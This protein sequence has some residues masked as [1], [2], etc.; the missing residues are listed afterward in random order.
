MILDHPEKEMTQC[1]LILA[2]ES[3]DYSI[4]ITM[5]SKTFEK[6]DKKALHVTVTFQHF[7]N[8]DHM[9]AR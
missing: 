1:L 4:L 5:A 7:I 8:R 3:Q 6:K 2:G 9:H